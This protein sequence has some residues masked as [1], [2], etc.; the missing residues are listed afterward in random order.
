MLNI[1]DHKGNEHKIK[2]T[3]RFYLTCLRM[4]IIKNKLT[5]VGKDMGERT[6]YKLLG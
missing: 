2:M 4:A 6:T 3:L 1:P 5:N